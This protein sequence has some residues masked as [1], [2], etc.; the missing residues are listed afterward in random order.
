M[1]DSSDRANVIITIPRLT[2]TV[3]VVFFAVVVVMT[4]AFVFVPEQFRS[5]LIFLAAAAAAAGQIAAA[6]YTARVLQFTMNSQTA[7]SRDM[8]LKDDA[9]EKRL[10]AEV[11]F[12][13]GERWNEAAMFHMRKQCQEIIEKRDQPDEIKNTIAANTDKQTNVGNIL[14]FLEEL[15]LAV[16]EKK[17][18][19][20]IAK[21]LFCGI[22]VNIWHATEGWVKEKRTA[23]GR[24]QIWAEL[25]ALYHRW[26]Q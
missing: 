14:N 3:G 11:S 13:F 23:R 26:K 2:V 15:A 18:D 22:V 21:R 1:R 9:T 8:Y 17:C 20:A 24:P 19:E 10:L 16:N 7:A 4:A 25:E 12:R 6:L 5:A